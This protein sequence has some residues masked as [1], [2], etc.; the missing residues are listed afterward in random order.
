MPQLLNQIAPDDTD[1]VTALTNPRSDRP[2]EVMRIEICN[3]T[4]SAV[5]FRIFHPKSTTATYEQSTA[6][7]YDASVPANSTV[8][9]G[10]SIWLTEEAPYLGVQS[11]VA[12]A[13]TFSIYGE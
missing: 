8:P 13:L 9:F 3:T 5:T 7:C 10:D 6:L 12:N 4:S 2:M 1:A 11:G